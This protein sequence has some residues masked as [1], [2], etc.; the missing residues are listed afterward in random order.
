[1]R[2]NVYSHNLKRTFEG[3]LPCYCYA[4]KTKSAT[5]RKQVSQPSSAGKG[6][7]CA[8]ALSV[9]G[10]SR[11]RPYSDGPRVH[12][13]IPAYMPSCIRPEV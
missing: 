1:M 5:N 2:E 12:L 13:S 9:S 10:A 8:L 6:A 4:L 11:S 7:N 3:L